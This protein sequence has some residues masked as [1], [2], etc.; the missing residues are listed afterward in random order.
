MAAWRDGILTKFLAIVEKQLQ[1]NGSAKFIVSN[2]MTIADFALASFTF[3]I[4]KNELGPCQQ[5]CSDK[6][7]EY[8]AFRAYSMRLGHELKD[9]LDSRPKYPF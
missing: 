6:L 3:N 2:E 7:S 5:L 4:L 9:Y 1:S 8:P